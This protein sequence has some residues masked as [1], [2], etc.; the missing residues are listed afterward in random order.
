MP[1]APT[2]RRPRA[3]TYCSARAHERNGFGDDLFGLRHVHEDQS[4]RCHIKRRPRQPGCAAIAVNDFYVAETSRSDHRLSKFDGVLAA[5]HTD[6]GPARAHTCREA[7]RGSP[8]D[9]NR[10]QPPGR[11]SQRRVIVL[12]NPVQPHSEGE[13][14]L[15]GADPAEPPHPVNYFDDPHDMQVMVAVMR[16][17]LEIVATGRAAALGPLSSRRTR[18]RQ[19]GHD[20]GD[21]RATSC[22]R[23]WPATTR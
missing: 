15:A 6:H 1:S 7:D 19:H 8:L 17:A 9:H 3:A 23:T 18:R 13:I 10:S 4:R 2:V 12:A 11:P 5:L 20:A 22:W 21:P 16:K 14:V